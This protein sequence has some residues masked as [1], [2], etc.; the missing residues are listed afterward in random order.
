MHSANDRI[1]AYFGWTDNAAR[2]LTPLITPGDLQRLVPTPRYWALFGNPALGTPQYYALFALEVD[3]RV[4]EFRAAADALD[5]TIARWSVPGTFA[6]LDTSVFIHHPEKIRDI[7]G[8]AEVGRPAEPVHLLIPIAVIDELDD[9]KESR[10]RHVRWRAGHTTGVLSGLFRPEVDRQ[11]ELT[12]SDGS[13]GFRAGPVTAEILFDPPGH[14][15][16]PITDDEIVARAVAVVPL[17]G[18]SMTVIT[19]DSGMA[20]RARAAGLEAVRL[21]QPKEPEPAGAQ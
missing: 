13:R 9:L 14:D 6:V 15:R 4:S 18:R 19:Y 10:D 7:P 17:A 8:A 21:E 12:P 2:K 11:V 16:L 5:E 20:F 1:S 3:E